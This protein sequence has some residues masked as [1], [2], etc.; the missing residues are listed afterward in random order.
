MLG[1]MSQRIFVGA[2]GVY[3]LEQ[4]KTFCL[5]PI[6]DGL[7]DLSELETPWPPKFCASIHRVVIRDWLWRWMG[8]GG[9][10]DTRVLG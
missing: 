2:A 5:P 3:H 4:V 8:G 1:R 9:I 7:P 10:Q 6:F